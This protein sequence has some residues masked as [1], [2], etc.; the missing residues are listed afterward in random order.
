M[1]RAGRTQWS[2]KDNITIASIIEK[3]K[4]ERLNTY[5]FLQMQLN[6]LTNCS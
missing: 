3:R 4:T 5:L 6:V 2:T 1:Q